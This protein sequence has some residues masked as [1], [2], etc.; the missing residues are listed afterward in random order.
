MRRGR[1]IDKFLQAGSACCLLSTIV[2]CNAINQAVGDSISVGLPDNQE[3]QRVEI[4]QR[5]FTPEKIDQCFAL[6]RNS[7]QRQSCRDQ[8]TYARL[9]A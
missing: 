2:G 9:R 4:Y 5:Y 1:V 8:I 6:P 3:A 7:A